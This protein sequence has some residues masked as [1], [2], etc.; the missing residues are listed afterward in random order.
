MK[1]LLALLLSVAIIVMCVLA[2]ASCSAKPE[3]NLDDAKDNLEDEDYSV[4]YEDDEDNLEVNIKE[5]LSASNEDDSLTIIVYADLKSAKL[6]EKSFNLSS[7]AQ[8]KNLKLQLETLEHELNAYED[9]LDSDEIDEYEDE[10]KEIKK[11]I[12]DFGTDRIFGRSGKTVW[13]GTE[14]AIKDSKG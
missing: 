11:E 1:K 9:E 2:F 6:A 4:F 12:E 8:L 3:L 14:N 13:Y 5:R 7:E 10:I